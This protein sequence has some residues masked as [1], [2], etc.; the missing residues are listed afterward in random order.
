MQGLMIGSCE[1]HESCGFY[2]GQFLHE[3]NNYHVNK[4]NS[5]LWTWLRIPNKT[6][7]L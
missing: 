6:T 4:E 2:M 1:G 3:V 7:E 5:V